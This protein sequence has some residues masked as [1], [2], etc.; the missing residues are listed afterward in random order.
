M[1][2]NETTRAT[3]LSVYV[4]RARDVEPVHLGVSEVANTTDAIKALASDLGRHRRI[5]ILS[6]SDVGACIVIR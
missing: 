1:N 4:Q 5:S 6:R 2:T 3:T